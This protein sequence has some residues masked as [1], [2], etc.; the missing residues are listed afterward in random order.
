MLVSL[1]QQGGKGIAQNGK[2]ICKLV[3]M[4]ISQGYTEPPDT[5]PNTK[6][7]D[8]LP[9]KCFPDHRGRSY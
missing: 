9:G 4:N 6:G 3:S 5:F 8:W 2:P 1:F 7:S